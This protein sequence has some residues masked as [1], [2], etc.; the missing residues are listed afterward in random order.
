M[1]T[2]RQGALAYLREAIS[3]RS[4]A[5]A[6]SSAQYVAMD[7]IALA[8]QLDAQGETAEAGKELQK[9]LDASEQHAA[10]EIEPVVWF[11]LA[12]A[13]PEAA[14]KLLL[15]LPASLRMEPQ[16]VNAL[17]WTVLAQGRAEEARR[18]LPTQSS[19]GMR[20]GGEWRSLQIAVDQI[21]ASGDVPAERAKWLSIAEASQRKMGKQF[22]F[23]LLRL[24]SEAGSTM[25]ESRRGAARLEAIALLPEVEAML[26]SGDNGR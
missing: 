18:L 16:L 17:M 1:L 20:Q 14:E 3:V 13:Q 21:A 9:M 26:K 11:Y 25:W 7:R 12:H 2:T 19:D 10:W 15:G 4:A 8:R 24:R 6:K 22:G 23:F 5:P